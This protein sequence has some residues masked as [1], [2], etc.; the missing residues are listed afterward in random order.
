M[1][2]RIMT[3]CSTC[4]RRARFRF[5]GWARWAGV[6]EQQ[7]Q[8]LGASWPPHYSLM[9]GGVPALILLLANVCLEQPAGRR[10][11]F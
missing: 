3:A 6:T 4:S 9:H 10:E 11:P 7:L 5:V 2:W 1:S 8:N